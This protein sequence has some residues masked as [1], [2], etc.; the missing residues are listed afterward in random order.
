MHLG[1]LCQASLHGIECS[2]SVSMIAHKHRDMCSYKWSREDGRFLLCFHGTDSNLNSYQQ[3]WGSSPLLPLCLVRGNAVLLSPA[4]LSL[5]LT[6]PLCLCVAHTTYPVASV[7]CVGCRWLWI[8]FIPLKVIWLF[9]NDG[10]GGGKRET[11]YSGCC[12]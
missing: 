7:A 2:V 1:G 5:G 11:T 8:N 6:L 3:F 12:I 4:P 9:E 10:V